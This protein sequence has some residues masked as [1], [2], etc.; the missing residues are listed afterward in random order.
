MDWLW[1]VSEKYILISSTYFILHSENSEW[2]ITGALITVSA[3]LS[4]FY[5]K[6]ILPKGFCIP[7]EEFNKTV[8]TYHIGEDILGE[9]YYKFN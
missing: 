5:N 1:I 9:G 8:K 6:H 4:S 3:V 7:P 2:N